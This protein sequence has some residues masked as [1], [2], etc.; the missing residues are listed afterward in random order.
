MQARQPMQRVL[1]WII[2]FGFEAG[3]S[4]PPLPLDVAEK[5]LGLG[6]VR[7]GVADAGGEIVGDVAG[8]DSRIAPVPGQADL[9]DQPAV[10]EEGLEALGDERVDLDGAPRCSRSPGRR[11]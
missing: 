2:A 1:S 7:V 4:C 11:S 8:H 3:S 5:D 10:D 6:D 9:V